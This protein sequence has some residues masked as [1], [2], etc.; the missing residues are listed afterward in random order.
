M[1]AT[2]QVRPGDSLSKIATQNGVTLAQLI[3]ANPIFASGDRNP[4]QVTVGES[5]KLPEPTV[6]P[7]KI[8]GSAIQSC[9][10]VSSPQAN[11]VQ[12]RTAKSTGNSGL[13]SINGRKLAMANT[14]A[15]EGGLAAPINVPGNA[16][17]VTLPG[18]YDMGVDA[19][20]PAS[21]YADLTTAGMEADTAAR[22]AGTK[23][24]VGYGAV[25]LKGAEAKQWLSD[26]T[27]WVKNYRMAQNREGNSIFNQ[28]YEKEYADLEAD[29]K[30][31]TT[32]A[33]VGKKYGKVDWDNLDPAIKGELIDLRFRG[34]N[35]TSTRSV[36]M[37]SV[38]ANNG[39][40]DLSQFRSVLASK[41]FKQSAPANLPPLR[42]QQR[43]NA[44][45][46]E[47]SARGQ[48]T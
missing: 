35:T 37:P 7:A 8:A 16:S 9:P 3:A 43:L 5:I 6:S 20:A 22:F 25:E 36:F 48:N 39:H 23:P 29:T 30:R 12:P 24:Y 47:I 27:D 11:L 34:D 38:V 1:S 15:R 40:G 33:D 10:L 13:N 19:R 4:N 14:L 26:N 32:K 45:D 44:L 46:A 17:G 42:Q 31:I 18:G 41:E 28:L 2:Y 21:V